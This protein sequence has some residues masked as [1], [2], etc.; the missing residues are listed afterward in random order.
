MITYSFSKGHISN[1]I[2]MANC[3]KLKPLELDERNF[4]LI[5]RQCTNTITSNI[6]AITVTAI[7]TMP[8]GMK[9]KF[10]MN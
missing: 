9:V 6:N 8:R 5:K 4:L 2:T 10:S 3:I 7:T 1:A